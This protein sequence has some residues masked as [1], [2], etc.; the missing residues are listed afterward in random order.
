V[1]FSR[2]F[3]L[4]SPFTLGPAAM[5]V[6]PKTKR[7]TASESTLMS[8]VMNN[9]RWFNSEACMSSHKLHAAVRY[10]RRADQ[11]ATRT[12][13]H[14]MQNNTSGNTAAS[15]IQVSA[16]GCLQKLLFL[17]GKTAFKASI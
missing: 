13:T 11:T 12:L 3:A 4:W 8:G 9:E 10:T 6:R 16:Q 2:S 17:P 5:L 14:N 15:P 1:G 7:D